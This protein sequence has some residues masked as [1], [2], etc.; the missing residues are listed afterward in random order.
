MYVSWNISI[1]STIAFIF[2]KSKQSVA[3]N[4]L[5][6]LSPKKSLRN[7]D[8]DFLLNP[9]K[10]LYFLV[11]ASFDSVKPKHDLIQWS[12]PLGWLGSSSLCK[13]AELNLCP[14][15]GPEASVKVL[16]PCGRSVEVHLLFTFL[17]APVVWLICGQNLCESV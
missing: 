4:V 8:T 3:K 16:I 11:I 2:L 6:P 13:A 1:Q 14:L 7:P 5:V 10:K 9:I 15:K 17:N 12:L